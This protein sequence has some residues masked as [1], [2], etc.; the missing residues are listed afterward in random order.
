MVGGTVLS[1]VLCLAMRHGGGRTGSHGGL[2]GNRSLS[3]RLDLTFPH[4]LFE[5]KELRLNQCL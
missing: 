1:V 2:H 3:R 5:G 4:L